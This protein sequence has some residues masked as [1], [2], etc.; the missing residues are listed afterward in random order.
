M[1]EYLIVGA[2]FAGCVIAEKLASAGK[3]V[4]VIEKRNHIGGNAYDYYDEHGVLIHKYGPHWFH[5]NSDEVIK[6]LSQFTAWI[7][8]KHVVKSFVNGKLY[9]F[10][11]NRTTLN[12]FFNVNLKTEEEAKKFLNGLKIKF[13]GAPQNAEEKA[14]SLVGEKLYNAFYKNYTAK[15]WG[16]NPKELSPSVTARIP[17]RYDEND[18]YFN[19]K[20]M[21]MPSEGYA[22]IF[23]RMCKNK[24]IELLLNTSFPVPFEWKNLIYTG[25]LDELFN[26]KLGKLPYRSLKFVHK[27]FE[28]EYFQV[29]QQIN[30][31]NE[32]E[33]TRIVEWKHATKQV[34]NGTSVMY[35][36]PVSLEIGKEPYYPVLSKESLELAKA[37]KKLA[38]N[39]KNIFLVGRLAEF[40]Y[41]NMDQ[42]ILVALKLADKLLAKN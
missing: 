8:H 7:E 40:K 37:Y 32:H 13:D 36:Y 34:C 38:R 35:E 41:Y 16:V 19:D 39:K 12:L 42:V 22:K 14:L 11:V 21:L 18:A 23:E 25:K 20:F 5:T 10:P 6:Y 33:Y 15:Q 9:P 1:V 17:I 24:N 26:Y 30:Y 29:C 31:P 3:K 27:H 2:G 28:K 4:V